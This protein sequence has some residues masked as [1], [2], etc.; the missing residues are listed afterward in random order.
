VDYDDMGRKILAILAGF[1]TGMLVVLLI[2]TVSWAK[3]PF[4]DELDWLNSD[5]REQ[6]IASL[7]ESGL[8]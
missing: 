1:A 4:P 5:H 8:T 6:Y 7:P 3:Y 2:R